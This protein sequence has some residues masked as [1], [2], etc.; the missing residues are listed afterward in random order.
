M[1]NETVFFILGISLVV[2]AVVVSFVG[3]RFQKFPPSGPIL[4]G[5]I[6]AVA[7]LVVATT[8]FAWRNASDEK[9]QRD[10][11]TPQ[12]EASTTTTGESTTGTSTTETSTTA[13]SSAEGAE[14]F[15]SQGCSGCHTLAA[16][17]S[18]GTTG[19]DLDGALKGKTADFIKTSIVEPNAEIAEG[20]PPDVMPENF[21]TTLTDDQI[22]SLVQYL[23]EST[24]GGSK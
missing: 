22:D 4:A 5:G 16:A 9:A 7:A 14:L 24:S 3:L 19:P 23:V 2:V 13:A 17:S 6:L 8:T 18:T 15:T 10:A 20:Y 21:G 12:T 1:S 11:E